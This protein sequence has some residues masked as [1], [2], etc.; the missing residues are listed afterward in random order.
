[1]VK[2]RKKKVKSIEN[3]D[4]MMT[5]GMTKTTTKIIIT[6]LIRMRIEIGNC[7]KI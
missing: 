2:T 5:M 4:I 1:M 7:M 3:E 6:M